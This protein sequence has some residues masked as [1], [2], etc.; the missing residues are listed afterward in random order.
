MTV[1]QVIVSVGHVLGGVDLV[2]FSFTILNLVGIAGCELL[3]LAQVGSH[4]WPIS[5]SVVSVEDGLE[6]VGDCEE[7]GNFPAD[8]H[9]S[10]VV[11]AGDHFK[12]EEETS[13]HGEPTRAVV[14]VENPCEVVSI[15]N[16]HVVAEEVL[17]ALVVSELIEP[18][19]AV[20]FSPQVFEPGPAGSLIHTAEVAH[21]G[22]LIKHFTYLL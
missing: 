15:R 10:E 19:E 3:V 17:D 5:S 2:K 11:V 9:T 6:S 14:S 20:V 8:G 13:K 7:G 4:D 18:L 1:F 16:R 22:N 21:R 12:T